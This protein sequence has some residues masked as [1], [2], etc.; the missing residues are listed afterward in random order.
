M[1]KDNAG[2]VLAAYELLEV[3]A[4]VSGSI[5]AAIPAVRAEIEVMVREDLERVAT[6]VVVEAVL[7]LTGPARRQEFL[8]RLAR[9]RLEVM[10]SGS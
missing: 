1:A 5:D 8:D 3:V 6:A 9:A 7:R 10:W 2:V 4:I